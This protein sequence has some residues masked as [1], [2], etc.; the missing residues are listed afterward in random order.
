MKMR[1]LY[2]IKSRNL[3]LKAWK[4]LITKSDRKVVKGYLGKPYPPEFTYKVTAY[5]FQTIDDVVYRLRWAI[6]DEPLTVDYPNYLGFWAKKFFDG[7]RIY[8][9]NPKRKEFVVVNKMPTVMDG[10]LYEGNLIFSDKGF[11][12]Y[13]VEI[14]T[15]FQLIEVFDE[16]GYPIIKEEEMRE[17]LVC[18]AVVE[19]E[20]LLSD[21]EKRPKYVIITYD[22]ESGEQ[23]SMMAVKNK[24]VLKK[25]LQKMSSVATYTVV[26][27]A[28]KTYTAQLPIVAVE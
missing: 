22:K 8:V 28:S 3:Y 17:N 5:N 25:Q 26:Y 23:K 1:R 4:E 16:R 13:G 7:D 27:K 14:T 12:P 19:Q 9:Y 20:C 10:A 21:Y 11:Q 15:D 18:R 24:K 2:L 6:K